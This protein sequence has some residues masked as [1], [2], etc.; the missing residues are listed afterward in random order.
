MIKF[1]F[2]CFIL[3]VSFQVNR[4]MVHQTHYVKDAKGRGDYYKQVASVWENTLTQKV[5]MKK[6]RN[7][8]TK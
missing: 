1:I 2:Y 5:F 8:Q 3:F 4:W 7:A 6:C